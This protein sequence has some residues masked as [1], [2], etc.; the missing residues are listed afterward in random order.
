M[1]SRNSASRI[2][3]L[4]LSLLLIA[5]G[6]VAAQAQ[7][8]PDTR[9]QN[10]ISEPWWFAQQLPQKE[11]AAIEERWEQIGKDLSGGRADGWDGD[12]FVGGETHGSYLRWSPQHGFVLVH[13]NK[14]MAQVMGFSYG[15]ASYAPS[16]VQFFPEYTSQA[17]DAGHGHGT[18]QA[19]GVRW[20]PVIWRGTNHLIPENE[21]S[22]FGDFLAGLGQ[23]NGTDFWFIEMFPFYFKLGQQEEENKSQAPIVP[24]GYEKFLKPPIEA[25]ITAVGKRE[26]K[27]DY[28]S[29]SETYSRGYSHVSMQFV[30]INAGAVHGVKPGMSFR[31]LESAIGDEVKVIK[32][33]KNTSQAIVFRS[34]DE[35]GREEIYWS[36]PQEKAY[37]KIIVGWKLTTAL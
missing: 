12:Y 16:L 36:G 1:S 7:L 25:T 10:G 8:D 21:M 14:C 34:L 23:F 17:S 30:T 32:V 18:H 9:W 35:H 20:I 31:G 28:T 2:K 26:V 37:P 4:L 3:S 6:G 5:L 13:V 15:S 11:I 29:E 24:P 22:N 27:R 33:G 19:P